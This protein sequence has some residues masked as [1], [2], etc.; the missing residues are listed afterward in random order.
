M[1]ILSKSSFQRFFSVQANSVFYRIT[2]AFSLFFLGPLL[3]FLFLGIKTGLLG[4]QELMYC[5]L[6]MLTVSLGGYIILKQ[7]A[8]GIV[9]IEAKM[10]GQEGTGVIFSGAG[11]SELKSIALFADEM[12]K[13]I[14][15]VS[16]SLTKRMLEI[17]GLRE[18]STFAASR[19]TQQSMILLAVEKA[20]EIT[21][22]EGAAVFLAGREIEQNSVSCVH[23]VGTACARFDKMQPAL[24]DSLEKIAFDGQKAFLLKGKD[25]LPGDSIP[26]DCLAVAVPFDGQSG[27]RAVAILFQR[28]EKPWDE[29]VLDFLTSFFNATSSCL[30]MQELG[31]K[32]REASHELQAILAILKAINSD[33]PEKDLLVAVAEKLYE[34][35]PHQWLGIALLDITCDELRLTRTL[36]G[37][38][39]GIPTDMVL[40]RETSLFQRSIDA[41]ARVDCDDLAQE[42]AFF[43]KSMFSELGLQSCMVDCLQANGKV[44]GSICL[45]AEKPSIYGPHEKKVFSQLVTGISLALEQTRLLSKER[46][47]S[48]ELEALNRIGIAL[49]SSAFDIRRVLHYVI[50]TVVKMMHVEAGTIMLLFNDTLTFQATTGIAAKNLEGVQVRIG[51]GIC[52]W[53]A[54]TGEA[55]IIQDVLANSHF[56][57]D[58]DDRTGLQTRNILCV[59]MISNGRVGGIVQLINKKGSSFTDEDLRSIK[60]IASST[61]IALDNTRLYKESVQLVEKERLIRTVFQ[62]YVPEEVINSILEKGEL[63]HTG[64]GERKIITVFNIDI[65]GYSEMSKMAATEDVVGVLNYFYMKMGN[66]I[67]HHKGVLDKY[68]GD[69][70]LAIFG[71]PVATRNPALDA[72][73]AAIEMVKALGEVSKVSIERCGIPLKI[74]ISLNTGEAIVGNIGFD[75][76]MEYTAIGDVVN[77]TFRLQ[78]LTREK[79]DLILM[80][81]STYLQVKSFILTN[82]WGIRTI[83]DRGGKMNV[84]EVVARKD[85]L[86]SDIG[87][88]N[89][90]P[91]MERNDLKIH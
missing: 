65:R 31:T 49:T 2:L 57:P 29:D 61:A 88:M 42:P 70:F 40:E 68:L 17:R 26:D 6:G 1:K 41:I 33:I 9:A 59:P 83:D 91:D 47:K 37:N 75:R 8:E 50:E 3:G 48:S 20:I 76:K 5:F 71:A 43:E 13:N 39:P 38:F 18:I 36:R 16:E 32:E 81:E 56:L 90:L 87:S 79:S 55:V 7:I 78:E 58:I 27:Q 89:A 35:L 85:V 62:K 28:S 54:A 80:S 30:K 64:H 69:G 77:E 19:L 24:C 25:A 72:T 51:Q 15:Q 10:A 73:L 23:C 86:D 22:A 12:T 53:V 44:I 21:G 52:G 63:D 11:N 82:H 34:V 46:A 67:L 14:Q 84:Y 66:I 74:G 45:G 4:S 60:S